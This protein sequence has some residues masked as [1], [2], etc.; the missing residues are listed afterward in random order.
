MRHAVRARHIHSIHSSVYCLVSTTDKPSKWRQ[1]VRISAH[2]HTW[3][4]HLVNANKMRCRYRNKQTL[5]SRVTLTCYTHVTQNQFQTKMPQD[6]Y[7][8]QI[9][10]RY[11]FSGRWPIAHNDSSCVGKDRRLLY[12]QFSPWAWITSSSLLLLCSR[13]L[14][15]VNGRHSSYTSHMRANMTNTRQSH[16]TALH[17]S[18]VVRTGFLAGSVQGR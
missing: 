16:C 13:H 4:R 15:S 10:W 3:S 17:S 5:S 12:V 1:A 14:Q 8:Y 9:W 11:R 18:P 2:D 6:N 7:K